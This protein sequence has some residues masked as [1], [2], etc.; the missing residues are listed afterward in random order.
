LS[1]ILG[2]NGLFGFTNE[3]VL[4]SYSAAFISFRREGAKFVQ[5]TR[6]S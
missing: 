5:A 6:K 1:E 2:Q 3:D 4:L